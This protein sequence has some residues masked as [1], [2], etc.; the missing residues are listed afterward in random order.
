MR[1]RNKN[2]VIQFYDIQNLEYSQYAI[3]TIFYSFGRFLDVRLGKNN[4]VQVELETQGN[5]R[6]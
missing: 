6:F 5:I 1:L 3:D 2:K 4:V